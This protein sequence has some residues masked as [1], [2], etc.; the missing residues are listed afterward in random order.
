MGWNGQSDIVLH[1]TD[2]STQ[3]LFGDIIFRV[4]AGIVKLVEG[5]YY[6]DHNRKDH[7]AVKWRLSVEII[8]K[9]DANW[10]SEGCGI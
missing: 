4:I 6:V 10:A 8:H 9:K 1:T 7:M 2:N 5:P 3:D